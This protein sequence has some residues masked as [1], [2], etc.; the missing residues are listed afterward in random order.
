MSKGVLVYAFNNE[1]IDYIK[2]AEFLAKR[3]QQYLKLPTSIVTD[4]TITSDVFDK[5]ITV[6]VKDYTAKIYN[7]GHGSQ[8]LS[9]KNTARAE[10]YNLTPYDQ[11]LVMDTDIIVCDDQLAHCFDQQHDLCMYRDAYDLAQ[12]RNYKEFDKISETSVDFYWATCVYFTKTKINKVF[13]DLVKHIS[14]NWKHYRMVYQIVQPTFRNDFAFSIAVHI[15]NNHTTGNFVHPMPGKLYYT[16]DKDVLIDIQDTEL[17]FLVDDGNNKFTP[18][19][20]KDMTIH[21]MN[22]F[23]LEELL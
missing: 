11:T 4:A 3:I 2:Q 1:S 22:K 23:S 18:I 16:L 5:V 19:K 12:T 8:S 20:T 17:M 9:F 7:N 21:A 13:F 15:M 6:D 14:E 10:S